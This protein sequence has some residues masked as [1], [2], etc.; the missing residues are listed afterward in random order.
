MEEGEKYS[1][2]PELV[3]LLDRFRPADPPAALRDRIVGGSSQPGAWR[4]ALAAAALLVVALGLP[5]WSARLAHAALPSA[6][7]D[8]TAHTLADLLGG[9]AQ[10]RQ[11]ASLMIMTEQMRAARDAADRDSS[12]VPV[13]P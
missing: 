5:A 6:A 2:D 3:A 7:A 12:M 9:D 4:W 8:D 1:T 11:T 13:Q 10:A